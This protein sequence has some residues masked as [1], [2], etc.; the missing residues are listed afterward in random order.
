MPS[1]GGWSGTSTTVRS[2]DSSSRCRRSGSRWPG[3]RTAAAGARDLLLRA[4]QQLAL[5]IEEVRE[6]ARGLHPAALTEGGLGPALQTLADRLEGL[7]PVDL[8]VPRSRFDAELEACT[9]YLVAEALANASKY[10]DATRARCRW[11]R[12]SKRS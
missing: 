1:D 3:F 10:A 4:E 11:S 2:S 6:I 7:L 5:A 9:Y 8:D 12:E